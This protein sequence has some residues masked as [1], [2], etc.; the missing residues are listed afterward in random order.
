MINDVTYC[1]QQ[2]FLV[3]FVWIVINRIC[4]CFEKCSSQKSLSAY[5]SQMIDEII[6]KT[7]ADKEE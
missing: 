6:K 2:V 1:I 3:I 4:E 5:Y 7:K